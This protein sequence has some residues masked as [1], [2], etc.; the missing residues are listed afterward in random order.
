[1]D[2]LESGADRAATNGRRAMVVVAAMIE[3]IALTTLRDATTPTGSCRW[4]C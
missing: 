1:M 4:T 2:R 3:G